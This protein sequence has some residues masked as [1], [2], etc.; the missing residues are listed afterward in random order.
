MEEM[1]KLYA[2]VG[3]YGGPSYEVEISFDTYN[4]K[5]KEYHDQLNTEMEYIVGDYDSPISTDKWHEFTIQLKEM[6]ILKWNNSYTNSDILDGTHWHVKIKTEYQSYEFQ[7][8]NAYPKE[9]DSFC[10]L[11]EN[12]IG[13]P[14]E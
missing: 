8:S 1:I 6:S 3:G 2:F 4:V 5:Y 9:W 7:G 13:K 14:F 10:K 11:I 12:L